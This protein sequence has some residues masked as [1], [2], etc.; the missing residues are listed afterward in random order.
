MPLGTPILA[1]PPAMTGPV[2]T[3]TGTPDYIL[4]AYMAAGT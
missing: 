4:A 1:R 3:S 2:R